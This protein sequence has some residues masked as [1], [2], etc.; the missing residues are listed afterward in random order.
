MRQNN[1]LPLAMREPSTE[2]IAGGPLEVVVAPLEDVG[3]S[4]IESF[5]CHKSS[6][7]DGATPSAQRPNIQTQRWPKSALHC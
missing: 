1:E 3:R 5:L 4:R 6:Y 2:D 7:L